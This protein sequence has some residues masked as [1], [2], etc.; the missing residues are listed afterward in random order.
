[1]ELDDI[2]NTWASYDEKLNKS[3]KLNEEL[4]RKLNLDKSK[5][6]MKGPFYY[7][8]TSLIMTGL[9]SLSF[10]IYL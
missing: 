1:M 7:E 5:R 6:E 10:R 8:T 4:L 2:K 9:S 3:L